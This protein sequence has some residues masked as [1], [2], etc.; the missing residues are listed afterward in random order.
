MGEARAPIIADL[1]TRVKVLDGD[2]EDEETVMDEI[3]SSWGKLKATLSTNK[4]ETLVNDLEEVEDRSLEEFYAAVAKN[5]PEQTI[6]ML[7]RHANALRETHDT[8]KAT[9]DLFEEAA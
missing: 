9:Q 6:T 5:L 8:M 4:D 1:S 2:I 3:R 7:K